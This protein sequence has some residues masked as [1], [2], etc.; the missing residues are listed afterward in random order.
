[1]MMLNFESEDEMPKLA[2]LQTQ[3]QLLHTFILAVLLHVLESCLVFH[4]VEELVRRRYVSS[5]Q[6]SLNGWKS[7]VVKWLKIELDFVI[8]REKRAELI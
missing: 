8:W 4:M 7:K 3:L 5:G 2:T 1:M 6:K